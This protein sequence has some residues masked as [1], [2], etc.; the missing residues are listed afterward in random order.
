L[1]YKIKITSHKSI[2]LIDFEVLKINMTRNNSNIKSTKSYDNSSKNMRSTGLKYVTIE[3]YQ[4][5]S[6][7]LVIFTNPEISYIES[8]EKRVNISFHALESTLSL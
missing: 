3:V 8:L 5:A 2:K 4:G 7:T 6:N 1:I